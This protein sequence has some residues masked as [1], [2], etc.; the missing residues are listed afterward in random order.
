MMAAAAAASVAPDARRSAGASGRSSSSGNMAAVVATGTGA[1]IGGVEPGGGV[2]AAAASAAEERSSSKRFAAGDI[3]T[4]TLDGQR[5]RGTVRFVGP[6]QFSAGDWVGLELTTPQ[7]KNDG[8]VQGV[9]Y[10]S[11]P[12]NHGIFLREAALRKC[13]ARA[14]LDTVGGT[15]A[16][17]SSTMGP[18]AATKVRRRHSAETTTAATRRLPSLVDAES[19]AAILPPKAGGSGA[20]PT[21][22]AAAPS[23]TASPPVAPA[24]A[25]S[26]AP[27]APHLQPL[28]LPA[29][30][31]RPQVAPP[32]LLD[33]A[34]AAA[35]GGSP[36]DAA[37]GPTLP[38]QSPSLETAA[39]AKA[40]PP[41]QKE[42]PSAGAVARQ[43][44]QQAV[45]AR[46]HGGRSQSFDQLPGAQLLAS[47]VAP[48]RAVSVPTPQLLSSAPAAQPGQLEPHVPPC[49][50]VLIPPQETALSEAAEKAVAEILAAM[51]AMGSKA[52]QEE[53]VPAS[54]SQLETAAQAAVTEA[55][56]AVRGWAAAEHDAAL[57]KAAVE[58]EVALAAAAEQAAKEKE[59]ALEA[60]A[61]RAAAARDEAVR[62]AIAEAAAEHRAVS[63]AACDCEV[64]AIQKAVE[65]EA[66]SKAAVEKAAVQHE[67]A[68]RDLMEAALILLGEDVAGLLAVAEEQPEETMAALQLVSGLSTEDGQLKEKARGAEQQEPP[69]DDASTTTKTAIK[70]ALEHVYRQASVEKEVALKVA[71]DEAAAAQEAALKDAAAKAAEEM[72][73]ALAAASA[74]AT[75]EKEAAVRAAIAQA[76]SA[77]TLPPSGRA[78]LDQMAAQEQQLLRD[79]KEAAASEQASALRALFEAAVWAPGE[80]AFLSAAQHIAAEMEGAVMDV[81]G[82]E[83]GGAGGAREAIASRAALPSRQPPPADDVSG[84]GAAP[85]ESSTSPRPGLSPT[86]DMEVIAEGRAARWQKHAPHPAPQ[87]EAQ[88]GRKKW[89]PTAPEQPAVDS[90]AS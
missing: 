4:F 83:G 52:P 24:I 13:V 17:A 82:H 43:V 21:V 45:V 50:G 11:C 60:A 86:R 49:R 37:A 36:V 51:E 32:P 7:G 84:S 26:A 81:A 41:L 61:E 63:P 39:A 59:A 64:Q 33:A 16:V 77:A 85:P 38:A 5:H 10:F 89:K 68:L 34:A 31:P 54:P 12:A 27:T 25:W 22:A 30:V 20:A 74:R 66:E 28:P 29:T 35:P 72:D 6:A 9:Q 62:A 65:S 19:A 42:A 70:E 46:H 67:A 79:A 57:K 2:A 18:S 73:R 14:S 53:G 48:A 3:V 76:S 8:S 23:K 78:M 90:L 87:A 44:L 69:I 80:E 47:G 71:A 55:L 88:P 75:S 15:T 58:K 56:L 40:L 1:G